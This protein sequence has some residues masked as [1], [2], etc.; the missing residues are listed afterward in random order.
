MTTRI[1]TLEVA[2]SRVDFNIYCMR[3]STR[4]GLA[5]NSSPI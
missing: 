2:L 5:Y 1:L 3:E 4:V